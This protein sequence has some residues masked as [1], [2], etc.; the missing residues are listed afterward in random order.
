M[1]KVRGGPIIAVAA[2]LLAVW[3]LANSTLREAIQAVIAAAVG[4]LIYLAYRIV[5]K[6]RN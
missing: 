2:L 5:S 4:I 1:F 6:A 3:L